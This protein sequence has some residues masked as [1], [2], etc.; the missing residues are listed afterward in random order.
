MTTME[1]AVERLDAEYSARARVYHRAWAPVLASMAMPLLRR[2]PLAGAARVLDVGTGSGILAPALRAAAPDAWLLGVDRARGMLSLARRELDCAA[3]DAQRLALRSASFDVALL[4]YVL[5]HC[6]DPPAALREAHRVLRDGGTIGVVTWGAARMPGMD[7]W[8]EELDAIG[9]APAAND[10]EVA[11]HAR[12][13]TPDKLAA[14]LDEAGFEPQPSRSDDFEF[15][16]PVARLLTI[17]AN[18]GP[19][20]GRLETLSLSARAECRRRVRRRLAQLDDD[21]RLCRLRVVSAVGRK[22]DT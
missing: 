13:N 14:L 5:F 1:T 3:M 8:A 6:P 9:A 2:L 10:P 21:Q 16:W 12:M 4:A 20:A 17:Q 7:L 15:R 19:G 11:Q 22:R 18:C